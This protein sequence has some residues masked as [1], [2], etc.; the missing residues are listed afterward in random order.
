MNYLKWKVGNCSITRIVESDTTLPISDLLPAATPQA[1]DPHRGWLQPYFLQDD[2][3]IKISFHSLVVESMGKIIVVD[4]CIGEHGDPFAPGKPVVHGFLDELSAAG[5]PRESVDV[6]L[7]THLHYDHVGW[8]T[9]LVNGEW[10]PTF[11]KAR[12]LFATK[13]YEHWQRESH[14]AVVSNFSN[15]VKAVF[16]AGLAELVETNHRI[17]EEVCLVPTPGHSPGHV[18]V[19][20]QSL[21]QQAFITGD[22]AHHPVQWAE[23]DWTLPMVDDDEILGANTRRRIASEHADTG[24]LIIGTHYP[25]PTAGYL[26]EINGGIRFKTE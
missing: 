14:E 1:I 5:F 19:D 11:P 3:Q 2:N 8:N 4:T 24:T 22:M 25:S 15:A 12:Y 16:D 7:C 20:V 13:E 17:T 10:V 26:V 9:M 18:S 6:V 21:Q 23:P